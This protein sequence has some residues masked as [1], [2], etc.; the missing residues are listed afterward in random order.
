MLRRNLFTS[1]PGGLKTTGMEDIS[2][3]SEEV[4]DE[5][6]SHSHS[7]SDSTDS[8]GIEKQ[9]KFEEGDEDDFSSCDIE[10]IEG[11]MGTVTEEPGILES[12]V[13]LALDDGVFVN[14]PN[15]T[16]VEVWVN[17]YFAMD[18]KTGEVEGILCDLGKRNFGGGG[19]LMWL[20]KDRPYFRADGIRVTKK[21]CT[22][23]HSC[24]CPFV[25]RELFNTKT[26]LITIEIGDLK[27]TQH[28]VVKDGIRKRIHKYYQSVLITSP[29]KLN[30]KPA[31]YI[32]EA[33]AKGIPVEEVHETTTHSLTQ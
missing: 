29:N 26:N 7:N 13:L 18:V 15:E 22:F 11:G 12:E 17:N 24:K 27:H 3:K 8:S 9:P 32:A 31:R 28:N 14:P 16:K 1:Q 4:A 6:D 30:M 33:R 2:D 20:A 25:I 19:S 5:D 10:E 21:R 23:F